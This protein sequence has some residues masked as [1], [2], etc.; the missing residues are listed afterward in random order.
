MKKLLISLVMFAGL[1][2]FTTMDAKAQE[3]TLIPLAAGDTLVTSGS[4]DTVSKVINISAGY[5]SMAVQVVLTELS[6]TTAC[7]AYLYQSLDGSNYVITDSS[8]AFTDITTNT[9]LFSK[10]TVPSRYVKVQVRN[11]GG[12]LTTF[13]GI[14]RIRY[15]LRRHD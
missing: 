6:G 10:G 8:A 15:V 14:V 13:S 9:A 1:L 7:K 11:I 12:D 4:A 5:A 3:P 2:S